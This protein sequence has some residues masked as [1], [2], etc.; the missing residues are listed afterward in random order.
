MRFTRRVEVEKLLECG[1]HA[2]KVH[3]MAV[4]AE[5]R[6]PLFLSCCAIRKND[7]ISHD[8]THKALTSCLDLVILRLPIFFTIS[9]AL[10][11]TV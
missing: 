11:S 4:G 6:I 10:I 8:K 1:I 9:P 3:A 2:V 5:V 7:T